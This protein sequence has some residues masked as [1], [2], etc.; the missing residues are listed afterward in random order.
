MNFLAPPV[1]DVSNIDMWNFKM[2]AYLKALGMYVYL[3]T[4]K[5]IYFGND[6][7]IETNAQALDAL[8]HKLSKEYLRMVSH[9]DSAFAVW[10]TL[11]SPEL[12]TTNNVE[13]ESNREMSPTK[14]TTWSKG[15][16]PL[17]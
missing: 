8:K 14:L 10:N 15:M 4:T 5:K 12:Q 2:S 17:R 11:T 6:K 13:K 7:Y 3:T 9:C 1:Y 16:T